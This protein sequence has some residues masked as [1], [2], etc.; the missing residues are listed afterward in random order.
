MTGDDAAIRQAAFA[1]VH[2]LREVHGDLIRRPRQDLPN[3]RVQPHDVRGF[4]ELGLHVLIKAA[5]L[6]NLRRNR[7]APSNR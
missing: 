4:I 3:L 2:R 6:T 1:A 7:V 5:M